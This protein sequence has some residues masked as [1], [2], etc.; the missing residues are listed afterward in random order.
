MSITIEIPRLLWI[1]T[2]SLLLLA[3]TFQIG[4]AVAYHDQIKTTEQA[5]E[6]AR[7]LMNDEKE[8]AIIWK[9]KERW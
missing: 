2:G 7:I 3:W 5:K 1:I 4:M 9:G 6:E 8:E